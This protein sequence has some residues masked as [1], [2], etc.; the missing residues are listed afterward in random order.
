MDTNTVLLTLFQI[1]FEHFSIGT[2]FSY[3]IHFLMIVS[4]KVSLPGLY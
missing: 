1:D 2:E 3:I 4:S